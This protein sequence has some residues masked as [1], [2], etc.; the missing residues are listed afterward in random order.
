MTTA[1][2]YGATRQ[3]VV[4][5]TRLRR[6]MPPSFTRNSLAMGRLLGALGDDVGVSRIAHLRDIIRLSQAAVDDLNR[7]DR[8]IAVSHATREFHV[9]QRLNAGQTTVIYNGV[10]CTTFQPREST[11]ALKRELG[12]PDDAFLILTVGQI[13]LRKGQD[14]LAEAA[15]NLD[16]VEQ[17]P[18]GRDLHYVVVGERNS[19]KPESVEFE[20]NLTKRFEAAGMTDR[21]HLLGYRSD[22]ARLMNEADLLAHPAHQEPAGARAV[23]GGCQR[24]ADR[25]DRRGGHE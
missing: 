4:F 10:D 12:L 3:P 17:Q 18:A 23:R 8:L 14:V 21:L 11:G 15:V 1:V 16:A 25:G 6:P 20:R 22:V 9:A 2:A 24:V 13:G 7:N 5:V 19:A